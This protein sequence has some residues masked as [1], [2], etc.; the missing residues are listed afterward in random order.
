MRTLAPWTISWTR[1]SAA[2]VTSRPAPRYGRGRRCGGARRV[3]PFAVLVLLLTACASAGASPPRTGTTL[4]PARAEATLG[5]VTRAERDYLFSRR[6][7]VPVHGVSPAQLRDDFMAPRSGGRHHHAIDILAPRLTPVIAADHGRVLALRSNTLGGLILYIV[8]DA[9]R[10]VYYYA[11]MDSYR[12]GLRV[13]DRL[14]P[15][16]VV[17]YVGS[18]G[19]ASD[20]VP[21]LHLQIMRYQPRRYWEGVPV[22]PFPILLRPGEAIPG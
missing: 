21:H 4:P 16:E 19:N 22:N 7:M 1:S 12:E 13:G 18:T 3:A 17:G 14:R 6:L 20:A 10:F 2:S 15:G 5:S 9:E 8:D 11:H